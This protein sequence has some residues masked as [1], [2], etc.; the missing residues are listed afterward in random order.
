[1]KMPV[2]TAADYVPRLASEL[3]VSGKTEAKAIEL[4]KDARTVGITS[5]KVPMS[6]AAAAIFVAGQIN[7]DKQTEKIVSVSNISETS[8]RNRY[9]E[10]IR[11]FRKS[12]LIK[13]YPIPQG[14]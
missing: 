6:M 4:L 3:G 14:Y 9:N 5:G 1:M 10:M 8:I 12:K 7:G 11:K 13:K 2:V